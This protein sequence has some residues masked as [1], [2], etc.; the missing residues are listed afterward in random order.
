M[1]DCVLSEDV[2]AGEAGAL[3]VVTLNRPDKRNAIDLE[4]RVALAEAIEAA[5]ADP[6]VRAVVLT[7]AGGTFCSGGDIST[8]RR[9]PPQETVAR[10]QAAQR[11]IRAIW[12]GPKPAVAA[13]EGSAF[14]AGAALAMACDRVVAATDA[15]FAATFTSVGLAGDMGIFASLPARV[16]PALARQLLLLPR[17]LPAA[18]ALRLG[19]ADRLC[20]PGEALAA[21]VQDAAAIAAGPPLAIAEIRSMFARWPLRPGETL[22]RETA[23]AARLFDTEDF[24]EGVAAFRERRKPVFR[25]R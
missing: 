24:S 6:A 25:G 3:R 12:D 15:V 4:L 13:V 20:Q 22:D 14:G 16:G 23:A 10:S 1:S 7:G 21:A 9:Q 2:P 17:P 5:M 11:V 18:D 8:M 19:L